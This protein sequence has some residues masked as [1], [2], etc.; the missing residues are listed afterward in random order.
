[1]TQLLTLG[2]EKKIFLWLFARLIVPLH[3]NS[4]K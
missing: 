4:K 2:K 1:M 3:D